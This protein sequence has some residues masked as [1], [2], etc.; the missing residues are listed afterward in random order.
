MKRE[1][2]I[3]N[4]IMT[5]VTSTAIHVS[6][7]TFDDSR[8]SIATES[9]RVPRR[10]SFGTTQQKLIKDVLDGHINSHGNT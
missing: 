10:G 6:R 8:R 2:S 1:T 5:K 9:T 7:F 4:G 3:V